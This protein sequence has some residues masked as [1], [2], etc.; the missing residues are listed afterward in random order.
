MQA[1]RQSSAQHSTG[2]RTQAGKQHAKMNAVQ[3]GERS[4]PAHHRLVMLALGEDPLEFEYL[5]KQLLLSYGPGEVLW[6]KQIDDLA[7]LYWR[8]QRLERA[9]E[10]LMRGALLAAEERQ[11]RR[12]LEMAG[13]TFDAWQACE[14]DLP[15]P[16]DPGVRLRMQLS[17]LGAIREQAKQGVFEPWQVEKLEALYEK[18]QGW[19]QARLM[20]LLRARRTGTPAC[21]AEGTAQSFKPAP[22]AGK[23]TRDSGTGKSACATDEHQDLLRL[24][25]EEIAFLETEFQYAEDLNKEQAAATRDACLAPDCEQWK[26]LVRREE[27]LDRAIDRKVR[28]L[29]AM[30]KEFR[31]PKPPDEYWDASSPEEQA[32]LNEMI[33]GDDKPSD[34][35]WE[36]TMS[37]PATTTKVPPAVA[38]P[39]PAK[40]DERTENVYENKGPAAGQAAQAAARAQAK[41]PQACPKRAA[42]QTGS[43]I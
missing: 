7:K 14:I 24:L 37:Q 43:V 5:K 15:V 30:R 6:E 27:A 21:P 36:D 25:D 17:Y 4:D 42:R 11:H 22:E 40:T 3:H 1:A 8:R 2:P 26:I 18:K 10:G 13:A 20:K 31:K 33:W 23:L 19:R 28:I 29:L 32:E 39:Q 16:A 34:F 41:K 38:P 35:P 12:R 9:Q